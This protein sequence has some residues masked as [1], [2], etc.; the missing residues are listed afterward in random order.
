MDSVVIPIDVTPRG[1]AENPVKTLVK[2]ALDN[3]LPQISAYAFLTS[4]GTAAT[5]ASI[6]V[7]P[8]DLFRPLNEA[9]LSLK[10][11][12]P[13]DLDTMIFLLVY[14]PLV[15]ILNITHSYVMYTWSES[16]A[17]G[18]QILELNTFI[19]YLLTFMS[20]L[21][22][23]ED[24]QYMFQYKDLRY[25][26]LLL[27]ALTIFSF[28][29]GIALEIYLVFGNYNL[30]SGIISLYLG[31]FILINLTLLPECIVIV[32]KE[33]NLNML[34]RDD[35]MSIPGDYFSI[36]EYFEESLGLY[37]DDTR[38]HDHT[39]KRVDE[40]FKFIGLEE[41]NEMF[42]PSGFV[43][44]WVRNRFKVADTIDKSFVDFYSVIEKTVDYTV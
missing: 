7:R 36:M 11:A 42:P 14:F 30:I 25:F 37:G 2:Y 40:F 35:E 38:L 4:L 12:T 28:I 8:S 13:T 39:L 23:Y 18:S 15:I 29:I 9:P 31:Y 34:D 41:L 20:I 6:Y 19:H 33:H 44:E 21:L 17:E 24:K 43:M 5:V 22:L 32:V 16:W 1:L 3:Y 27:S 26:S 10:V